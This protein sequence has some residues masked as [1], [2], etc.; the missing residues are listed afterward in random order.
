MI[1]IILM[2]WRRKP[3]MVIK[4]NSVKGTVYFVFL[5]LLLSVTGQTGANVTATAA[6]K[7][8]TTNAPFAA[9]K[10]TPLV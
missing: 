4:S 6:G 2:N 8:E 7:V 5:G 9:P 1:I 3:I 10:E